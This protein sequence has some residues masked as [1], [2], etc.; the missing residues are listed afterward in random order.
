MPKGE[1]LF[2]FSLYCSIALLIMLLIGRSSFFAICN[3]LL[4]VSSGSVILIL[5]DTTLL[6]SMLNYLALIHINTYSCTFI[7]D[8]VFTCFE[9]VVYWET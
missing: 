6:L 2:Y 7:Y 4:C 3:S 8:Y 5:F 1:N 9:D